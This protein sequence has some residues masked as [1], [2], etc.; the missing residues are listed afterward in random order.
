MRTG[1]AN[2]LDASKPFAPPTTPTA[3]PATA[4]LATALEPTPAPP[5]ASVGLEFEPAPSATALP[6]SALPSKD[7]SSQ[8][9]VHSAAMVDADSVRRVP[10]S[11]T[12]AA[13]SSFR[14]LLVASARAVL[15][16]FAVPV[17][18]STN[19]ADPRCVMVVAPASPGIGGPC[20]LLS[21]DPEHAVAAASMPASTSYWRSLSASVGA[22]LMAASCSIMPES[23]A[24]TSSGTAL[25]GDA[26]VY[27]VA[28]SLACAGFR[29]L[30]GVYGV[31]RI[32]R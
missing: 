25:G 30:G 17:G 14:R 22:A 15:V 31:E 8:P 27:A 18:A 11:V 2:G 29:V 7:V 24:C 13:A 26:I 23:A 32:G 21:E 5:V 12:R 20:A 1:K 6:G 3:P 10:S 16:E 28:R 4:P 19:A 9:S